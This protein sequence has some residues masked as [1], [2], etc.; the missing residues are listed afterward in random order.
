V[1][2]SWLSGPA[3]AL[4]LG[5]A[6]SRAQGCGDPVVTERRSVLGHDPA[7]ARAA[8]AGGVIRDRDAAVELVRGLLAGMP[9]WGWRGPRVLACVPS[10]ATPSERDAVVATVHAAGAAEVALLE[11]PV[12]AA[13][14][15]GAELGAGGA[16]LVVDVGEGVTDA[17]VVDRDGTIASAAIRTGCADLRAG[18]RTAVARACGAVIDD[19]EAERLLR[20]AGVARGDAAPGGP[21]VVRTVDAGTAVLPPEQIHA[22]VATVTDAIAARLRHLF[23]G[24]DDHVACEVIDSGVVCTG[25]G[26]LLPGMAEVVERATTLPVRVADDP[27][28]AVIRGASA[29]L[30]HSARTGL[31]AGRS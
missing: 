18:V 31:W 7:G 20:T 27:L 11:E 22:G 2:R 13:I 16:H 12:A 10:D 4:D 19:A 23:L 29:V 24:L 15:A 14:G 21:I 5:T 9:R 30:V 26:A 8:L 17:S 25:G 1:L 3:V 6:W 28:R